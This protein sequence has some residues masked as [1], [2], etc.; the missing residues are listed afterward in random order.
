MTALKCFDIVN[1]DTISDT[2]R[3]L[4]VIYKL[5]GFIPEDN[6]EEFLNVAIKYLQCG[7]T[8]E[9]QEI[10]KK[11]MDFNS[12]FGYIVASFQSDYSIDLTDS[13]MHFYKF[14]DLIQGLTEK[15]VLSRVR[16]IRNYNLNEIKDP[17][18]RAE[19][20]EAQENLKLPERISREDQEALDEFES[21]F[22]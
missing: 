2:E 4:A 1:D 3:S 15:S 21:L 5:F 19:M 16:S 9:N 13:D 18:F 11:D 17:K 6:F 12:D 10:K 14:V 20:A 8:K 22:L 7:E